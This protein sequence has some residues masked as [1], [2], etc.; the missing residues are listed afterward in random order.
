MSNLQGGDKAEAFLKKMANDLKAG[1]LKVG[2]MGGVYENGET[3]PEVAAK[4]E[5]GDP[6][7]HQ[8]PRPFFRRMIAQEKN[9]WHLKVS[10]L[11]KTQNYDAKKILGIMGEEIR[12]ALMQSINDLTDPALSKRT[13]LEKGFDKPL[14]D[15]G[16]M[17]NSV[18]YEIS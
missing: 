6:L 12:G 4:N 8:P 14:I 15:S 11:A 7:N 10:K 5:F 9:T 17:V 16:K 2:F 18:T 1:T 13:I 3:V